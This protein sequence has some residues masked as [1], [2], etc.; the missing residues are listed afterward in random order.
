MK[1][2]AIETG[3]LLLDGGAMFGTVPRALWE[4]LNPPDERNRCSW[5]L[6]CLLVETGSRKILV[7][8]G[9]GDKQGAK[10]RSHFGLGEGG[11]VVNALQQMGHEPESITDVLLTHLHFDHAGGALRFDD[12]GRLVPSFPGA[13]YWSN[14]THYKWAISPNAREKAS[15]LP[16]NFEP[17]KAAGLLKFI[18]E[19]KGDVAW[20]DGISIRFTYGHTE[21]MMAPIFHCGGRTLVFCA[22]VIPSSFH[23][24]LPYIMA[25]DI[26]PLQTLEEKERILEEGAAGGHFLAFAHDPYCPGIS[27]QRSAGGKIEKKEELG[28]GILFQA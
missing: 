7:D 2:T 20:L 24:G 14:E 22:D 1:I 28:P 17:L 6:R 13:T 8:T 15:F 21:A 27:L 10:F 16:E 3:K 11:G 18:D 25:Y 26:R 19:Q 9:I 5:A 12:G 23:L 4:Q